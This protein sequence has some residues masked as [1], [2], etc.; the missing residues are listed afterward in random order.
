[1]RPLITLVLLSAFMSLAAQSPFSLRGAQAVLPIE[2]TEDLYISEYEGVTLDLDALR[3]LLRSA[4]EENLAARSQARLSIELPTPEGDFADFELVES[5]IFHPDLQARH[6]DIRSYRV[7]GENGNGRLAISPMG[8]AAVLYG[9]QGKYFITRAVDDNPTD[10]L[11][12]YMSAMDLA[13]GLGSTQLS[14]GVDASMEQE[15]E[16]SAGGDHNHEHHH[17][18]GSSRSSSGVLSMRVYDFALTCT[19]QYAQS[20]GGTIASV[21]STFNEAMSIMNTVFENEAGIR[22]VLI[23]QNDDLI[24]LDPATAPFNFPD[25]GAFLLGE[26]GDVIEDQGI[27]L[28][29]YDIGHVFAGSCGTGGIASLGSACT[30]FKAAGVTC[31]SGGSVAAITSSVMTHE[32]GHQ[33]SAPHSWNNCPTSQQQ[34][35]SGSAFEP[36]SGSTIMSY[37][38]LCGSQNI[39][40]DND[41]Y[42]HVN[43]LDQIFTHSREVFPNC[44]TILAET[45]NE[46]VAIIEE[47]SGFFIPVSTPFILRGSGTDPDNDPLTYCWEQLDLGPISSLGD[48]V[49][50][51]PLFRSFPPSTSGAIRYVPNRS[52]VI[53]NVNNIRDFLPDYGRDITFR[54]TVRDNSD[55]AGAA[56]WETLEFEVDGDSGP[57][58][59]AAPNTGNEDWEAG[60]IYEVTWDVANT[61]QAPI[62][63]QIVDVAL[64]TDGGFTF[65]TLLAEGAANNGSVEVT[66]PTGITSNNARIRVLAADNIFYDM[67]N[68]D[69]SVVAPTQPG[70]ALS[71][72]QPFQRVCLPDNAVFDIGTS[73]VLGFAGDVTFEVTS[74]LP[75]NA[76][77]SFTN[78]TISAGE[79]A[80]LIID[81]GN[82]DFE[83]LLEVTIQATADGAATT[84]RS[85]LVEVTNND[86]SDLSLSAPS[87]GQGDIVLSTDFDWTDAFFADLYE[88]EIATNPSFEEAV[89]FERATDLVSSSYTPQTFFEPSSIYFWRIRPVNACGPGPW[90][91]TQSF[92]TA[93]TSCENF[94]N[95]NNIA[96]PGQGPGFTV[97]SPLLVDRTGTISD[98]N[99]PNIDISYDAIRFLTVALVSPED[100][101][102][103]LYD[104][105]CPNFSIIFNSG[106]DDQAPNQITCPPDDGI[107]FEPV[108]ELAAFEGDELFGTWELEVTASETQG[109]TGFIFGWEIEFCSSSTPSSPELIRLET[110]ECPPD[111]GNSISNN[112]LEATDPAFGP[113]ELVYT[114]VREPRSGYLRRIASD[115]LIEA[116]DT[117]TQAEL[118]AN[119]IGYRNTD[120]DAT[121]D[122]WRFIV[123]NP[124]GGYIPVTQQEI[125]IFEGATTSTSGIIE[126]LGVELFPNPVENRLEVRWAE[127][128][129]Q[130]LPLELYDQTGRRVYNTILRRG[131]LQQTIDMGSLPAATY[132]LRIDDEALP[133]VKR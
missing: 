126:K 102:V 116:G 34:R 7:F 76:V 99:I 80:Q 87:E 44:P 61:D 70:Y 86:F 6:P 33:F 63:C 50:N 51:T 81:F 74:A 107:V 1:M 56:V 79:S 72:T 132:W 36:G 38:G 41:L 97:T 83:G 14:C 32:V 5:S 91:D 94:V 13:L 31:H 53:N 73:S 12:Y 120:S 105:D 98:V 60:Q 55:V 96:L 23:P 85:L 66:M 121:E 15:A 114:V 69:F 124:D 24:F 71:V 77:A 52:S 29:Q 108:E 18:L 30:N 118:N 40:G 4:P 43:S 130:D 21:N 68:A 92:Q 11:A 133:V 111:G 100:E 89:I 8:I 95:N 37:A 39:T 17:S 129:S 90:S 78:S 35:S 119:V 19:G 110:L 28:S 2:S 20:K 3:N 26:V 16:T 101:R 115:E 10:Y 47:E 112:T 58:L 9:Q 64:S 46:P 82:T 22:F 109:S 54:L 27:S 57:F 48:P 49:Q 59:V 123:T 88:I 42:F 106:F 127:G 113:N 131:Q 122:N 75:T 62:N 65:P 84:T 93:L 104:Q 67:S 125:S 103:V 45:N 25:Q 128:L 117:F